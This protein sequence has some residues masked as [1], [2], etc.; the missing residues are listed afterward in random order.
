MTQE[1]TNNTDEPKKE[2]GLHAFF[3]Y[4]LEWHPIRFFICFVLVAVIALIPIAM[5]VSSPFVAYGFPSLGRA[6]SSGPNMAVDKWDM[7]RL[8]ELRVSCNGRYYTPDN[9][10]GE[11]IDLPEISLTDKDFLKSWA[12]A[13]VTASSIGYNDPSAGCGWKITI[14]CMRGDEEIRTML[15]E[16]SAVT[17][18]DVDASNTGA[19]LTDFHP[20]KELD[21]ETRA[22]FISQLKNANDEW[23]VLLPVIIDDKAA[24]D[25]YKN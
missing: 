3:R 13:T 16:H 5:V 23:K 11:L 19:V 21:E 1:T 7:M 4:H 22:E 14:I 12:R 15:I 2:S 8:T 9:N 10:I 24:E 6:Y 20:Y 25:I 18:V 17:L